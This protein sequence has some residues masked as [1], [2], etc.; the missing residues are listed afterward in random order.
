MDSSDEID[1]VRNSDDEFSDDS[2]DYEFEMRQPRSSR[3]EIQTFRNKSFQFLTFSNLFSFICDRFDVVF[4]FELL[5]R[6]AENKDP[7]I[8]LPETL[9]F[10]NDR[11]TGAF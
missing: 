5:W 10:V 2:D 7:N 9:V 6:K 4:F 8:W 3:Y 11:C 1:I